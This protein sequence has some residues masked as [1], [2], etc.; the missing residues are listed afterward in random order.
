MTDLKKLIEK[1][2]AALSELKPETAYAVLGGAKITV[3]VTKVSPDEWD[4]LV[5]AN[6]ART[7]A[8]DDKVIGYN[9]NGVTRAYP[10]VVVDGEEVDPEVW[11]ETFDALDSVWR[12]NIGTA[13]WR[14]NVQ[15]PFAELRRSGKA[16]AGRK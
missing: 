16:R 3:E 7:G 15:E 2:R 9:P 11:A 8:Q 1:Q 14:I 10:R 13:I 4:A 6:P 5:I 12:N